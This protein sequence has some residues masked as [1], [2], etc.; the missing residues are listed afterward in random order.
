MIRFRADGGIKGGGADKDPVTS[1]EGTVCCRVRSKAARDGC[2]AWLWIP[3]GWFLRCLLA[4]SE[5]RVTARTMTGWAVAMQTEA[6]KKGK[7]L[8][9]RCEL[10]EQPHTLQWGSDSPCHEP[11]PHSVGEGGTSLCQSW[12]LPLFFP[13]LHSLESSQR[14]ASLCVS[15]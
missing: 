5:R 3:L 15:H 9:K 6:N 11:S 14:P 7:R 12:L 13:S 10:L 8:H 4:E 2:D 1:L